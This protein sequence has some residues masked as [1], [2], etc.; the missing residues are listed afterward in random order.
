MTIKYCDF[1]SGDDSTGDGSYGNPY[2]TIT[3]ASTGLTG[4][5]EVRVAASPEPTAL[6]GTIAL[7]NN[8]TTVTGT[9]TLFTTELAIGDFIEDSGG[10]WWEVVTI[11]DNTSAT[12][13]RK[14]SG[15]TQSGTSSRKL[16]F[17]STGE[18]ASSSTQVQSISSVGTSSANLKISGGWTLASQTQTGQTYF[19]QMHGTFS[20]R[21]GYGL[22]IAN[23]YYLEIERLHF[24][25]YYNGIHISSS[26]KSVITSPICISNSNSGIYLSSDYNVIVVSPTA[27]SNN[28][29]GIYLYNVF[30]I[31]V[32]LPNCNSNGSYG[33]YFSNSYNN[34][35]T[36]PT[37]NSNGSYGIAYSLCYDNIC[38]SPTCRL[39]QYGIYFGGSI[40]N[41]GGTLTTSG[42][43][44]SAIYTASGT[45]YIQFA[46]V[47]EASVVS[48]ENN[49]RNATVFINDI[50]GYSQMWADGGNVV[51]QDATAGGTGKEWRMNVTGS[52]RT[53]AYPLTMTLAKVAVAANTQ[54]TVTAYFKKSATT[55]AGKLI[56][57]G[58]QI[59]GVADDVSTT[60]PD[61]TNRNNVQIQFT[62]TAAGVVEI[63][64][65]AW[66]VS[67]TTANILIDDIA[68][69]QA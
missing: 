20:T 16:G 65:E 53:T 61:D 41:I 66:Y 49:Y 37:C 23:K 57:R 13:Y 58:G 21:N 15:T 43:S 1:T 22:Y 8:S 54:V 59:A 34:M 47:E 52:H 24:L 27:N 7:T 38:I 6:T 64:A 46:S 30:N 69:S 19:R 42:N 60:C 40:N 18:A 48:S 5:D 55:I 35:C 32:E 28:S 68:I 44:A 9:D 51:S 62:P 4:G 17:T 63:E 26:Y 14:F 39:N 12:L 29:Y 36:F 2:K 33:I 3:T 56:I 50:S 25:R 11:T 45:N 31:F 10:D 67:A